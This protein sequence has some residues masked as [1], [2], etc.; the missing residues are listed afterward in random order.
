[1]NFL[2]AVG[3]MLGAGWT[4]EPAS[5]ALPVEPTA[6]LQERLRE[7]AWL[8]TAKERRSAAKALAKDRDVKT[9]AWIEAIEGFTA[10]PATT[11]G[12]ADLMVPLEIEG[13]QV[14]SA[15]TVYVPANYN[16]QEASP[17]LILLHGS[18]GDGP[19]IARG[20]TRFAAEEGFLL[21]APTDPD[22][23]QGYAFTQRK[24]DLGMAA[25]RWMRTR[26]HV[27]DDRI[28]LFGSS[29]GGHM[30]WDLGMRFP[31]RF[32]SVN[33]A[34][35]GPTWVINGGRNNLRLTE[36][37]HRMP[38]RDLQGSQDD[39]RLLRNL[40]LAFD[41]LKA[42]GNT[43]AI[44]LEFPDLGHS[45]RLE[46]VHWPDYF[47]SSVRE[48]YPRE[49]HYRTARREEH[50]R[51]WLRVDRTSKSVMEEFPIKVDPKEWQ[52]L[53]DAGKAAFIQDLA[54]DRTAKIHALQLENGSL[55]IDT[56]GVG[57]LDLLLPRAWIPEDGKLTVLLNGKSKSHKVKLSKRVLLEDFVERFDRRSL[58]QAEIKL[59][60]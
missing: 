33:P 27:D 2:A 21:L 9:Q 3:L 59:K 46:A 57:K 14:T 48:A 55:Q 8:P 22:S 4:Q 44:L 25:M 45:Y 16:P 17:L 15:L 20:W 35:G 26:Y 10:Y 24:R 29:R 11:I 47:E 51:A 38:M 7:A 32:A 37:L 12:L 49:I 56:E 30:A 34:I 54:E 31:D 5:P 23:A 43:R 58:A 42:I 36:N 18:G 50:R 41:R 19:G 28:H 6:D 40:H 39:P 52:R 1:M 13:K 53:D 60:P